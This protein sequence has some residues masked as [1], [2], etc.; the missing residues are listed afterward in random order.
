MERRHKDPLPSGRPK[1]TIEGQLALLCVLRHRFQG[2][3]F[4]ELPVSV[5]RALL[6]P[7]IMTIPMLPHATRPSGNKPDQRRIS[8]LRDHCQCDF[9]S[10]IPGEFE[11]AAELRGVRNRIIITPPDAS[12]HVSF[13][14]SVEF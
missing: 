10:D 6:A 4:A 3:S 5:L 11:K 1:Y 9:D 2:A 14:P 7:P 12:S 13:T 8:A